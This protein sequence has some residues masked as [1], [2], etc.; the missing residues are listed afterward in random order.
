MPILSAILLLYVGLTSFHAY[1]VGI[2]QIN[3]NEKD[4]N[5]E[6][7]VKLFIDDTEKALVQMTGNDGFKV[8][9]K[10]AREKLNKNLKNYLEGKFDVVINEKDKEIEYLGCEFEDDAM[11]LYL[12]IS[13]IKNLK[14]IGLQNTLLMEIYPSQTHIVN[15]QAYGRNDGEILKLE[16][17]Y[18]E[19]D[20]RK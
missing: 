3:F 19:F 10:I 15:M 5:V 7:S 13:G 2:T 4:K 12:Q 8:D 6:I 14:S 9:K 11:W 17:N 20:Y 1:Y 16:A 18:C